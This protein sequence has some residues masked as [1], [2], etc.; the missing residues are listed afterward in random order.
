MFWFIL[1]WPHPR[2]LKCW[3]QSPL[4]SEPVRAVKHLESVNA[5]VTAYEAIGKAWCH[6][7][8]VDNSEVTGWL[9]QL[10]RSDSCMSL[11]LHTA[12]RDSASWS[13]GRSIGWTVSFRKS[14]SNRHTDGISAYALNSQ[15]CFCVYWLKSFLSTTAVNIRSTLCIESE[16]RAFSR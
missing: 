4:W 14:A 10:F 2:V 15:N 9:P 16:V 13:C 12:N 1:W 5:S 7:N 3:L 8:S 11:P 6:R